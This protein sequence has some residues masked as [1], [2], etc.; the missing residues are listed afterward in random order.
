VCA[1]AVVVIE[2]MNTKYELLQPLK[3]HIKCTR[4]TRYS[5]HSTYGCRTNEYE[6][7]LL[8]LLTHSLIIKCISQ[9]ALDMRM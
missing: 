7:V 1:V 8:Q 5:V 3:L 6:V 4:L 2:R 9:C